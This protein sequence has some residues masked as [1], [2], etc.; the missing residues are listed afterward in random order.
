MY[1]VL[2][3]KYE[4]EWIWCKCQG[5]N[6]PSL[7]GTDQEQTYRGHNMIF[8][9]VENPTPHSKSKMNLTK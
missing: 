1:A 3:Y 9:K 2:M 8:N 4:K 5:D 6:I 7:N